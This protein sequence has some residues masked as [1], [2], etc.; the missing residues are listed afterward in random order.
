[1]L[2]QKTKTRRQAEL[3]LQQWEKG[4]EKAAEAVT[5]RVLVNS[6][7]VILIADGC[8]SHIS[9]SPQAR[10]AAAMSRIRG[11]QQQLRRY[12]QGGLAP[13]LD[14]VVQTQ[15]AAIQ[16]NRAS[17]VIVTML[18][19]SAVT[20]NIH[21]Q[22]HPVAVESEDRTTLSLKEKESGLEECEGDTAGASH[23]DKWSSVFQDLHRR[24]RAAQTVVFD[25]EGFS[26]AY[27][28]ADEVVQQ[29]VKISRNIDEINYHLMSGDLG[30]MW[31]EGA[32]DYQ[33]STNM[34]R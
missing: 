12:L 18:G 14:C 15:L 33:K 16:S 31:G 28:E 5:E 3:G 17:K 25:V 19:S 30:T 29:L 7:T 26:K 8:Y 22:H 1:M 13:F 4:Q 21:R 2:I 11:H 20:S 10:A 32:L 27:L 34:D 23:V 6:P 9:L 24:A